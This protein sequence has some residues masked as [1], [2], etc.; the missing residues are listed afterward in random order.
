M[1][2][3]STSRAKKQNLIAHPQTRVKIQKTRT[4]KPELGHSKQSLKLDVEM[5]KDVKEDAE[6]ELKL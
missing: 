3:K 6:N 2:S 4:E 1:Y 5:L